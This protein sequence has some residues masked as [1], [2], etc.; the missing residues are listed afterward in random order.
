MNKMN[1]PLMAA[2]LALSLVVCPILY[3]AVGPA[4]D[5]PQ[6]EVLKILGIVAACRYG[7]DW[8]CMLRA[9]DGGHYMVLD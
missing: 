5:G 6:L 4:L 2:L 7:E 1:I 3:F 9:T 8:D